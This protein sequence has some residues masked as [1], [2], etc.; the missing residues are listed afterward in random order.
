MDYSLRMPCASRRLL[1]LARAAALAAVL[2]AAGPC[3]KLRAQGWVEA[4]SQLRVTPGELGDRSRPLA[5]R[6]AQAR[7]L[8][9]YGASSDAVPALLAALNENPPPPLREAILRALA[10]RAP[11]QAEAPLASLLEHDAQPSL[12]LTT[13]LGAIATR[14]AIAALAQALARPRA[15]ATAERGLLVA[16]VKAAAPLSRALQ[17]P[18]ALRAAHVLAQLGPAAATAAGPALRAALQRD[19]P[20]L[21]AEAARALGALGETASAGALLAR[22]GDGSPEVVAAALDALGQVATRAQADALRAYL[23]RAPAAQRPAALRAL[24]A[25]DP[26]R[27][28]PWL[29]RALAGG[30]AALRQAAV[31]LLEGE[32]PDPSWVPLLSASF[33]AELR[34]GTASALAR[35]PGGR[36]VPALLARCRRT[37]DAA[38]RGARALA[39]A[40]RRDRGQLSPATRRGALELLRSLPS[41]ERSL[42]L[43]A[44]ARDDSVREPLI[45]A[46]GAADPAR[47]ASA[48]QASA[49]LQ[50]PRLGPALLRALRD[51]RDAEAARRM[52]EAAAGLG[53][54]VEPRVLLRLLSDPE[55]APEAMQLA[56]VAADPAQA[57]RALRVRLRRALGSHQPQRVRVGAALAL[58]ALGE[59][60]AR[61]ALLAALE[62][63][64]AR[65]RLAAA[66]ALGALGGVDTAASLAA[67]A[68]VERDPRVRQAELQAA[69]RAGVAAPLFERGDRVLEARVQSQGAPRDA[70]AGGSPWRP[71]LDVLLPDGRWLRLR[72]QAGGEL[73]VA[74][75][76][77]GVADVRAVD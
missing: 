23:A 52:A 27:A 64:S 55:T 65:L 60:S 47:R 58:A 73:I 13:A 16:G 6:V 34:E 30:D 5:E 63:G 45:A 61:P 38:Q 28:V 32:R 66:R 4:F 20:P 41:A 12:A 31:A 25:A 10:L 62:D 67:R 68:R 75:L 37:P 18:V 59:R 77:P 39:I 29:S 19:A 11:A 7:A 42:L 49:W 76:P 44:L 22:L 46:L 40:L 24:A 1:A 57:P 2:L 17:S 51:E 33:A 9:D 72:A 69:A 8:G 36:G 26:A 54:A 3:A 50:D 43:R 53:L 35:V 56:A 70:Q 48:A 14:P 71:L 15:A 74:D 21:R